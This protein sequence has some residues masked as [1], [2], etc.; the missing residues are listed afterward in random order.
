VGWIEEEDRE[1]LW[2]ALAALLVAAVLAVSC[3]GA[4]LIVGW[5]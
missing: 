1:A 4:W 3:Y 2:I 5:P